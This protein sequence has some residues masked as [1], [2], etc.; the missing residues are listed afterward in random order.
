MMRTLHKTSLLLLPLLLLFPFAQ[1]S[2]ATL[3]LSPASGAHTVG[4][5]VTVTM[6]VNTEGQASN[7]VEAVLAY[8]TKFFEVVSISKFNSILSLWVEEPAFSNSSGSITLSGGLPTPGYTGTAGKI[9]SVTFKAKTAGSASFIFSSGS[10]RANDGLGTDLLRLSS[11]ATFTISAPVKVEPAPAPKP[12]P[13][14][15]PKPEPVE[16]P[17]PEPVI[18]EVPEPVVAQPSPSELDTA[19]GSVFTSLPLAI[20]IIL[21]LLIIL[22]YDR[23]K[24]MHLRREMRR[25]ARDMEHV[26]RRS[27]TVMQEDVS[28]CTTLLKRARGRRQLTDEEKMTVVLLERHVEEAGKRTFKELQDMRESIEE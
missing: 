6:L 23:Y 21:V 11:G 26:L 27:L 17:A 3:Y 5:V 4:D 1:V 28:V 2:A 18:E 15:V 25:E 16:E 20:V 9:V 10:V 22:I 24:L 19:F 12:A 8:P 7:S 14:V 13:V